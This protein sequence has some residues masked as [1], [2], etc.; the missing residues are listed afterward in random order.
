MSRKYEGL[1]VLDTKGKDTSIDELISTVGQLIE[2][3]G[4]KLDEVKN[5]GRKTFAYNAR[6]IEGGHYVSYMF[7]ASPETIVKIKASLDLN[8]DIYMHNYNRQG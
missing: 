8:E 3:E 5:L 6:Q 7:D 4:A 1:V 2:A